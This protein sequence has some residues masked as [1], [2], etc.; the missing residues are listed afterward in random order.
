MIEG[1]GENAIRQGIT[2]PSTFEKGN[3]GLDRTA[4]SATL[5]S[6]DRE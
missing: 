1:V 4:F 2:D 6:K 3:K 5:F